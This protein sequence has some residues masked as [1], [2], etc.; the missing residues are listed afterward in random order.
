MQGPLQSVSINCLMH[1]HSHVN[2]Q[3]NPVLPKTRQ[4]C[5]WVMPR[6]MQGSSNFK[7]K[8]TGKQ[9]NANQPA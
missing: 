6:P 8:T 1:M 2:T 9:K 4:N 3:S 7:R 5:I